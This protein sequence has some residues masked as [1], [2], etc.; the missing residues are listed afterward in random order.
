VSELPLV[1]ICIPTFNGSR[2]LRET[3]ESVLNQT[4]ENLQIC[5][6]DHSSTD[7]TEEIVKSFHDSRIEFH[8]QAPGGGA[9]TNWNA[10]IAGARGKYIKL[11]CQDDI[12]KPECI[13]KQVEILENHPDSSFCFSSRDVISPRGLTLLPSRGFKPK[14]VQISL[15]EYL[16]ILVQSGTNMFGEPCSVLM[17]SSA[18]QLVQPFSGSYLIDLN[19]WYS[20]W[21]VAPAIYAP[22]TAA[23]FRISKG[24]WTTA[25]TGQQAEQIA[26]KFNEI[27]IEWPHLVN[28][29]DVDQ[30]IRRAQKLE[31]GRIRL[32]RLV[33]FLHI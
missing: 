15:N 27:L 19:M 29:S 26:S 1:S 7:N 33:E 21:K 32:M 8:S 6:S 24:S 30:G 9:E 16:P 20:L 25:L 5:I 10:S 11:L 2:F 4:Y 3:L 14:K 17:Q 12:L 22:I 28:K 13:S 31:K 23:K 18:L